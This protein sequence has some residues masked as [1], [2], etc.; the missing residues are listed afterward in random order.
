MTTRKAHRLRLVLGCV[1]VVVL[2]DRDGVERTTRHHLLECGHTLV[3]GDHFGLRRRCRK[4]T[5]KLPPERKVVCGLCACPWPCHYRA[6]CGERIV[7][8]KIV[9]D[10]PD[11]RE[12]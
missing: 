4:C 1:D 2:V 10:P 3:V 9:R 6:M 11:W 7:D 8:R 5:A 12:A